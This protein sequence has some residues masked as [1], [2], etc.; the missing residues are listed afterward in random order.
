MQPEQREYTIQKF[1]GGF[2][3]VWRYARFSPD[4]LRGVV[5]AIGPPGK[6]SA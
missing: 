1:R 5:D 6:K 3:I 2:A 4:F